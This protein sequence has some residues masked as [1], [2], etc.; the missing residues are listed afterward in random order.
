[1][2]ITTKDEA[3]ALRR[4]GN[5]EHFAAANAWLVA[6]LTERSRVY[7]ATHPKVVSFGN[8]TPKGG[9]TDADRVR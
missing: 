7:D 4:D 8:G 1:M 6:Y 5:P 2:E 3:L 9:W